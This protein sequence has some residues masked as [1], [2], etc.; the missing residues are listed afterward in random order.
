MSTDPFSV[1]NFKYFE[2]N[3]L[4]KVHATVQTYYCLPLYISF[5]S[6]S[7]VYAQGGFTC[8]CRPH[9]FPWPSADFL[10]RRCGFSQLQTRSLCSS[11]LPSLS[12]I[13][14]I[15]AISI[16]HLCCCAGSFPPSTCI[17]SSRSRR[18]NNT[19]GGSSLFLLPFK[20]RNKTRPYWRFTRC[21]R[22][23]TRSILPFRRSL[24]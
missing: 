6:H 8:I 21:S 12:R 13:T 14:K 2:L 7:R 5:I 11:Y 9:F 23:C 3:F 15:K 1:S 19:N 10:W 18:F 4:F 20:Q 16:S 22:F 24:G 17:S